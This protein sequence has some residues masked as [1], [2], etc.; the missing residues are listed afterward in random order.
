MDSTHYVAKRC[1]VKYEMA[2]IKEQMETSILR[3]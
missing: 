2:I 3:I 1:V